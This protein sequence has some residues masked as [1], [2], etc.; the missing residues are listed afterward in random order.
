MANLIPRNK[1]DAQFF[2]EWLGEHT[3]NTKEKYKT[4]N[5]NTKLKRKHN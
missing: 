1:S 4:K 3:L 5:K 2:I